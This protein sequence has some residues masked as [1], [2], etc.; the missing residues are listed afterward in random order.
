MAE[1]LNMHA[2]PPER[3]PGVFVNT[4]TA[5]AIWGLLER[6]AEGRELGLILGWPGVG[7]SFTLGEYAKQRP[8]VFVVRCTAGADRISGLLCQMC[9]QARIYREEKPRKYYLYRDVRN[10]LR[11]RGVVHM[12]AF[13]EANH[14][15]PDALDI[16]RDLFDVC[17]IAMVLLGNVELYTRLSRNAK[18]LEAIGS[19]L[20]PLLSRVSN[21]LDLRQNVAGDFEAI[22]AHHGLVGP[23][24]DLIV[25]CHG[26]R[27]GLRRVDAIIRHAYALANGELPGLRHLQEAAKMIGMKD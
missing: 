23:A 25:R 24:R 26:L 13:D 17:G 7:K 15:K 6:C 9:D 3:K 20:L 10:Y 18:Q 2:K 11:D 14:L 21:R 16:T 22:A 12:V 5:E 27:G 1:V 8:G 19:G 4:P